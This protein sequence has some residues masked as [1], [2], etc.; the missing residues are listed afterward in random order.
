MTLRQLI[1]ELTHLSQQEGFNPDEEVLVNLYDK[2]GN[3]IKLLPV[4]DTDWFW[5]DIFDAENAQ[6]I[7]VIQAQMTD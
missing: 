4:T 7:V 6:K 2:N 1:S 5:K 3:N